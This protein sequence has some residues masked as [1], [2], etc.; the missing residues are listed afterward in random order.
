M[1]NKPKMLRPARDR[2]VKDLLAH[3]DAHGR[4]DRTAFAI[5][6]AESGYSVRQL[7]RQVAKVDSSGDG[8]HQQEFEV[9]HSVI[10]TMFR[11]NG[12]ITDT[13]R[14]L[15]RGGHTVPSLSTF[16]RRVL[17]A[18]SSHALAVAKAGPRAS[19]DARVHLP[20][21]VEERGATYLL[22]HTELPIWVV[23]EGYRTASRPWMT[24]VMDAGSRYVLAWVVTFGTPTAEEVRAALMCAFTVRAAADGQTPVGGLCDRAMWDRGLDFLSDLIT[25]SCSRVGVIPIAL[26]AYSPHLKGS[27]ERFW[28]FLKKNAIAPLPGYIDSGVDVRG[29]YLFASHALPQAELINQLKQ[30][31][32]WYNTE[33][34]NRNLG[35]TALKAWQQGTTPLRA[36]ASE[37][38]WQDFLISARHKVGKMGVRFG[39]WDY[40]DPNDALTGLIGRT[41]EVRFLPHTREFIEV[42]HEGL[43]VA[44]CYPSHQLQTDDKVAFMKARRRAENDAR[45]AFR[46]SHRM[47][48]EHRGALEL[49]EVKDGRH[50]SRVALDAPVDLRQDADRALDRFKSLED[51]TG[52]ITLW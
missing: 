35:G 12:N 16:R 13:R 40:V 10:E 26:P 19:R 9:D 23:P 21:E 20:R 32:D 29:Q 6:A 31:I 36:I 43:H 1:P 11:H 4:L 48:N 52:Q 50:T 47:R 49:T 14:F 27:L 46:T 42:F 51:P 34:V 8:A 7:Q 22:D 45:N 44:T 33:H 28:R 24:V 3:R 37:Q 30:W 25:E 41:V 5:A 18:M 38:L 2:A 39:K 17:A 15:E